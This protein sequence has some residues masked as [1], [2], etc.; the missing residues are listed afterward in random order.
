MSTFSKYLSLQRWSPSEVVASC[1]TSLVLLATPM[2]V[3]FMS[4]SGAVAGVVGAFVLR[5]FALFGWTMLRGTIAQRLF[6]AAMWLG[7]GLVSGLAAAFLG[8]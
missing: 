7:A 4:W 8:L 1:S 2:F 5:H 3:P 6:L